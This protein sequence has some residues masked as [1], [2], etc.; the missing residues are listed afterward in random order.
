MRERKQTCVK[1]I[2]IQTLQL[3]KTLQKK[4]DYFLYPASGFLFGIV[5]S[6]P[7]ADRN[8]IKPL[9]H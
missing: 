1:N 7:C 9:S 3:Q 6:H 4:R 5:A 8:S 2:Y